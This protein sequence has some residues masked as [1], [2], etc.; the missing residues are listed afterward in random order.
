MPTP[1]DDEIEFLTPKPE[2][3]WT[4]AYVSRPTVRFSDA[5]LRRLH[6]TAEVLN[7]R[8]GLTGRLVV[9]EKNGEAVRF[10]QCIE[11]PRQELEACSRR[12][13][14]DAR[15]GDIEVIQSAEIPARRFARWSMQYETVPE[16]SLDADVAVALWGADAERGALAMEEASRTASRPRR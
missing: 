8:Y 13:F 10:V 4:F 16:A 15:H 12:I 11:G 14:G 2:P 1:S 7:E 5:E 3:L 9:V 6:H